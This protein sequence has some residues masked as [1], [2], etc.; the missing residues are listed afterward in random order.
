ME[1][2]LNFLFSDVK[3]LYSYSFYWKIA[4]AQ[5]FPNFLADKISVGVEL[6]QLLKE[7][8]AVR[9]EPLDFHYVCLQS[10]AAFDGLLLDDLLK[11]HGQ[12]G[13]VWGL[14]LTYLNPSLQF[15]EQ[16]QSVLDMYPRHRPLVE[17]ALAYGE[18][19]PSGLGLEVDRSLEQLRQQLNSSALPVVTLKKELSL[20][21]GQLRQEKVREAYRLY[22]AD[23]ALKVLKSINSTH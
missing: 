8:P 11:G 21:Q 19:A 23:A 4:N 6:S 22:G 18:N 2:K 10:L 15:K 14:F 12:A 20:E 5:R 13:F 7:Y 9:C 1:P 17:A 16:L 3:R